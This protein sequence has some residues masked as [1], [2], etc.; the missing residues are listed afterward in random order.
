MFRERPDVINSSI[1][2]VLLLFTEDATAV[3]RRRYCCIHNVLLLYTEDAT[4]V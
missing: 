2:N 1:H 4:A 3:Y